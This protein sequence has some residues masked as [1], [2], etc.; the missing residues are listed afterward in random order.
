MAKLGVSILSEINKDYVQTTIDLVEQGVEWIHY[1]IMDGLFVPN[2][3]FTVEQVKK[4]VDAAGEHFVDIHLMVNEPEMYSQKYL[5]FADQ[6]VI[7]HEAM[8]Y[9]DTKRL[10]GILQGETR[11]FKIGIAINPKT[12]VEQ[13]Y[14][15]L[16]LVD[17]ILVMSV[18][19]G[20]GGQ[21]F[22]PETVNKIRKLKK[23]IIKRNLKTKLGV[24]GGITGDNAKLIAH[25]GADVLISG[26]YIT[27]NLTK[28]IK[29]F[30]NE[31][32]NK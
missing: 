19:P 15:Y 11:K 14:E 2:K 22:I 31:L 21:K 4:C 20:K 27:N 7:H 8:N 30:N 5:S 18:V 16:S 17:Y 25:V 13:V 10:I 28:N 29:K 24:D 1:D 12:N 3:S 9:D 26:S 32:K 23:Y 6:I